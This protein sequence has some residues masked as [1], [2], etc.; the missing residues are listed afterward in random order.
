VHDDGVVVLLRLIPVGF[1]FVV[2]KIARS[3]KHRSP[4][5][6]FIFYVF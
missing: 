1:H 2:F 5:S 4:I 6:D 3:M